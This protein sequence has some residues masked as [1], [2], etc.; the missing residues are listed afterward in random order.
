MFTTPPAWV[1]RGYRYFICQVDTGTGMGT[2]YWVIW[3]IV[4][5][6]FWQGLNEPR[7]VQ[8]RRKC[9]RLHGLAVFMLEILISLIML[10]MWRYLL[11][12][13]ILLAEIDLKFFP[14]QSVPPGYG[15]GTEKRCSP[16]M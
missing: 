5:T 3:Q 7:K 16:D 8:S 11:E 10:K 4:I 9:S 15:S 1:N 13:K 14:T 6:S 2:V 12:S